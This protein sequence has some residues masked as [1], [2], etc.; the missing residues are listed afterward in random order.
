MSG[1][2]YRQSAQPTLPVASGY[3]GARLFWLPDQPPTSRVGYHGAPQTVDVMRRAALG[4]ADRFAT[5]QLAESVCENLDSKDYASE[6]LAL[7][8]FL[9]QR[10][11]YMRDP[12]RVELVRA[13]HL[14][15]EQIMAGHRPSLD[16]DDMAT[17]LAAAVLS[18][19]GRS[20]FVTVSFQPIF[21]EGQ[22]QF[23]HVFMRALEPR[24][25]VQMILDPV[26][27]ESTPKMLRRVVNSASWPVAS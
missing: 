12:R 14:I 4:D 20:E 27:A 3:G 5:R 1:Y 23:S 18:V 26:A 7:Y 9:L 24:T 22:P 11:R 13:P 8:N 10:T 19:G 15:S 17:W 21:F 16:C 6:Y 2:R 25:R